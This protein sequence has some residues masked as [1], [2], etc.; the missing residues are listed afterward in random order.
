MR[1]K[2]VN[3]P[4]SG[5]CEGKKRRLSR[6]SRVASRERGMGG[7]LLLRPYSAYQLLIGLCE[8]E[9]LSY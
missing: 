6:I 5:V 7:C 3:R 1:K 4:L 8:N 9:C 2:P